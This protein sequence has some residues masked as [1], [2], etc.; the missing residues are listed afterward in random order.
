[1]VF[2]DGAVFFSFCVLF[3]LP[4]THTHTHNKELTQLAALL[5]II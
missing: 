4:L 1:M 5:F 2:L 3:L